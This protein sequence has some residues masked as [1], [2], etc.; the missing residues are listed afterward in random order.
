MGCCR[1]GATNTPSDAEQ[2]D[3]EFESLRAPGLRQDL[4]MK[5]PE[6]S[7]QRELHSGGVPAA[8]MRKVV[9]TEAPRRPN[10]AGGEGESIVENAT[11]RALL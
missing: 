1:R 6:Q 10:G 11:V 2:Q 3:Q 7:A 9:T 4:C 8:R 5:S